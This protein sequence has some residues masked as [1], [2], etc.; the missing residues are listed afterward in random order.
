MSKTRIRERIASISDG[1]RRTARHVARLQEPRLG[2]SWREKDICTMLRDGDLSG[3]K[4]T[5]QAP[6]APDLF[7]GAI[8]FRTMADEGEV[9]SLSVRRSVRRQ[10]IASALIAKTLIS[11]KLAGVKSVFLEVSETNRAARALYQRYGFEKVGVRHNYYSTKHR[12]HHNALVLRLK[13]S[14]CRRKRKRGNFSTE[15]RI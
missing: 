14:S 5:R 1:D 6:G 2:M 13:L 9:L 15:K 7:V 8:L 10:G 12:K 4:A 11:M 3:Y